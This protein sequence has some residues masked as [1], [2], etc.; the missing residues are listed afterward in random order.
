MDRFDVA[1]VGLG[2]FGS[3]TVWQAARKGVK[4]VGFEQFEFGHVHGASHD[5]SRIV[6]TSYD[7][8][9]YVA[10]AKSAYKDWTELEKAVGMKLLTITGGIVVLANDRSCSA[11]AK[12]SNYTASLDANNV[13]YE[14]L[15]AQQ[16]KKR[17]P[18]INLGEDVDAVYTADTGMAHAAKSV[19]AM[20]FA[21]RAHG[22]V[23]KE[24]TTVI[25]VVPLAG[26]QNTKGVLVK[27][28]KGDFH[29]NKVVLAA[30]AWINKLL[31]PLG[32]QIPLTVMQEQV[33]YFKPTN[34]SSFEPGQFPV[35]IWIVDGRAFYGFPSFGEPTIKAARDAS[36]NLMSP[37]ERTY[38]H[39]PELLHELTTFMN[40]FISED[41]KLEALRTVTCQYAITPDRQFV[42][43]RLENHPEIFIALGAGHGF[44]FAPVIGRVMAELAIDGETTENISKFGV[45]SSRSPLQS[46]I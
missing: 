12:A 11:S 37:E 4:V 23:L 19:T 1:V 28:T 15:N 16:V 17:W 26:A 21:A 24:N 13:P 20:Q 42:L 29:A 22:A 32:A 39:S 27:T 36:D 45:P 33:T 34:P 38:V 35:W 18:Q 7:A 31:A 2:A 44:K 10:L 6:R 3:A 40:G 25:R 46:K 9:E 41:Q 5:T 30:D 8:P 43:G 14:L